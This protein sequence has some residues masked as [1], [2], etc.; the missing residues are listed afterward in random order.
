M[1]FVDA[2]IHLSDEEYADDMDEIVVEAKNS[3]VVAL[4]SNSMDYETSIGS[5]KL[6]EQ[7]PGMVYAALGIHPWNVN[8]LTEDELQQTLELISRQRQNKALVAIGEI[9]LDHKYTK[10]WDKQLIVFN[11]MLNLAEKF[12]LPVIIHSRGT[13]AKIVEM[14]PSYNLRKVLL[15]WFSNPISVLSKVVEHGYFITEGPPTAYSNG[16]REVV[17]RI[18]LANLLTE[19][20]GPV[21]YWK[22]PFKGKRTTPAFIPTVVKAIAE[23]KNMDV[24]D[25]AAQITK[26][27]EEFLE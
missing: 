7:Y 4:V 5:L 10:I 18:P 8:A 22:L 21:R 15:H 13:T 26:N 16:I 12:D 17:R 19:T 1:K 3:N 11:E 6:A 23:I 27:F 25:A 14:L 24:A 2:H 20:D 9:G